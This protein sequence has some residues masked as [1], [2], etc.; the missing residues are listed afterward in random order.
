MNMNMYSFNVTWDDIIGKSVKPKKKDE[1][2]QPIEKEEQQKKDEAKPKAEEPKAEAAVD[3]QPAVYTPD[4][5]NCDMVN[6]IHNLFDKIILTRFSLSYNK[7]IY[8]QQTDT[9]TINNDKKE[10]KII[11]LNNFIQFSKIKIDEIITNTLFKQILVLEEICKLLGCTTKLYINFNNIDTKDKNIHNIDAYN[12]FK[13]GRQITKDNNRIGFIQLSK[14]SKWNVLKKLTDDTFKKIEYK[15][16]TDITKTILDIQKPQNDII[17]LFDIIKKKKEETETDTQ[18]KVLLNVLTIINKTQTEIIQKLNTNYLKDTADII[19]ITLKDTTTR[20]I[21]KDIIIIMNSLIYNILS[22][23]ELV[24]IQT[25]IESNENENNIPD[26]LTFIT[27][28]ITY[29]YEKKPT[30]GISLFTCLY[31]TENFYTT[32]FKPTTPLG[33]R[34]G[35]GQRGR[36]DGDRGGRGQRGR[37]DG[38]RGGRGRGGQGLTEVNKKEKPDTEDPIVPEV[39]KL[40]GNS[41]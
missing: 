26:I 34:G 35:R 23:L 25:K 15:N 13:E 18:H 33:D 14:Y 9:I 12:H 21:N 17:F 10:N 41:E 11:N 22:H 20:K 40:W 30:H 27:D 4:K 2:V 24:N 1:P 39:R 19:T 36:R 3:A 7:D 38:D 16:N 32:Y 31:I 28:I 5:N 37:R 8:P 29:H 6:A